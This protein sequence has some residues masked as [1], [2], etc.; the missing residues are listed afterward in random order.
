MMAV[1][2]EGHFFTFLGHPYL[3]RITNFSSFPF[4]SVLP[5][6]FCVFARPPQIQK[7]GS[8]TKL[9]RPT[10]NTLPR[11]LA[12]TQYTSQLPYN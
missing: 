2:A 1:T 9:Q 12:E 7:Q 3:F 8:A 10:H 4:V 5:S 11:H 6:R